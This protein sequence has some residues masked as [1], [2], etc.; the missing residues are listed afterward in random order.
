MWV[1]VIMNTRLLSWK[2]SV[3]KIRWD[4]KLSKECEP[5]M[6]KKKKKHIHSIRSRF[7]MS[8]MSDGCLADLI[9]PNLTN[10]WKCGCAFKKTEGF[11]QKHEMIINLL[12]F[13]QFRV[14]EVDGGVQGSSWNVSQSVRETHND[15]HLQPI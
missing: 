3:H 1:D 6:F 7:D 9:H 5:N 2:H 4:S 12:L 14:T 15:S 8:D 13:I 11:S 10:P